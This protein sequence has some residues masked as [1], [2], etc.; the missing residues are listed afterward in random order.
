M[1]RAAQAH[2]LAVLVGA[3]KEHESLGSAGSLMPTL[4]TKHPLTSFTV[5]SHNGVGAVEPD[6]ADDR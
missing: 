2:R 6:A 3:S 1:V 5:N 4:G